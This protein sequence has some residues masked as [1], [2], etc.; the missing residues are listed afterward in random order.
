MITDARQHSAVV[1]AVEQLSEARRLMA[2]GELEEVVLLKLRAG[3]AAL[4]E[5][6]GETL[7]E[8][9]LAEIFSTFCIGK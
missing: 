6:T 7:T 5:I 9:I 8:D 1:R 2:E 3:L 4:G